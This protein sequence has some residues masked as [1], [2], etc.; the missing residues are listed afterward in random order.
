MSWKETNV[1]E[2][3]MDFVRDFV[4]H[5][6][7]FRQLCLD[8]GISEKTGHKWKNRF[9]SD[10]FAGLADLS[11][12]PHNS[13]AALNEDQVIR[14][15][16]I[17][18]AHPF[19]GAKKI[20]ELYL[21]AYPNQQVPSV[22]SINRVL[23][24]AGLLN[25]RRVR[26][27]VPDTNRLRQHIQPEEP[28]DVWTVDFKGWWISSHEKCLP[29]TVRDLKGKYLLA[30]T[31]MTS[32]TA[33][34]VRDVFVKLFLTYGLPKV[35]RSD[36]GVPFACRHGLLQ[37]TTLSCWWI[38]L[39]I[40]PD[41]I[42]PGKPTQNG[43]HE[44]MHADIAKEVQKQKIP[45]GILANQC[46]LDAWREEYNA[47]RPHEALG[48]RTPAEVYT[49]SPRIYEGDPET[50]EYPLGFLP[51]KVRANGQISLDGIVVSV[52]R[53]LR[54]LTIGLQPQEEGGYLAW[55][56]EFPLGFVNLETACF[57]PL[58]DIK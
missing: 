51:R 23:G 4:K 3:R 48:M 39:G 27:A 57:V 25:S 50:L 56:A 30:I 33:E 13:P 5:D 28:N 37:L 11:R 41:H 1:M 29:L 6:R 24:K 17:R 35:I 15:I 21:K 42:D 12:S 40:L 18:S 10:G 45:G 47:V 32:C 52:G 7:P 43:S 19:W 46:A 31:L 2:Q 44:R 49:R 54:R 38:S 16:K 20:N 36:N 22:S 53:A 58:T 8:Y 55:L 14:L 9:M 26:V 34:A